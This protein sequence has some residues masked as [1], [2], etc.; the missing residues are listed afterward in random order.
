MQHVEGVAHRAWRRQAADDLLEEVWRN[1]TVMAR[2][3]R[4]WWLAVRLLWP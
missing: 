3:P 4:S 2:A 1:A